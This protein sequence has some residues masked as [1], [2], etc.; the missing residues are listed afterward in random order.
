MKS[1]PPYFL[2]LLQNN[3]FLCFIS[4]VLDIINMENYETI[5]QNVHITVINISNLL[6]WLKF[7][8]VFLLRCITSMLQ[9]HLKPDKFCSNYFRLNRTIN[10]CFNE[11]M[12]QHEVFACA[13]E[14]S[15]LWKCHQIPG[16]ESTSGET[17]RITHPISELNCLK[18]RLPL[19]WLVRIRFLEHS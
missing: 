4:N 6:I 16:C 3:N 7:W 2:D 18:Q 1:S 5:T 19:W 15:K 12:V 14:K 9:N 8:S 13:D 11:M 10:V 17:D